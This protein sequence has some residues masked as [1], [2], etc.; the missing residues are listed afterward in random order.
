MKPTSQ[1]LL[2]TVL[3]LA[4]VLSGL[5]LASAAENQ[6]IGSPE[7]SLTVP[8]NRVVPGETKRLNVSIVNDGVIRRGGPERFTAR[9]TTARAVTLDIA[10]VAG[11]DIETDDVAV[12]SVPEGVVGPVPI[13]ITVP[14]G[15]PPGRYQLPIEV[16]YTFTS[17]VTYDEEAPDDNPAF[18]DRTVTRRLSIPV[19]VEDRAR[20]RV[21]DVS[22]DVQVGDSGTMVASVR[23]VGTEPAREASV[24]LAS[25]NAD[26]TFGGSQSA[27]GFVGDW[28][29]GEVKQVTFPVAVADGAELRDYT[30]TGQVTYTDTDGLV[31]GSNELRASV[32]PLAE[33]AFSLS[34]VES[35]LRVNWEGTV[36]G[37]V[38]NEGPAP[39]TDAVVVFQPTN[40]NF[41]ASETEYAI[42]DLAPGESAEFAFDVEVSSAADPGSRQLR[43]AVDYENE[44]GDARTSDPLTSRVSVEGEREP[45]T[46]EASASTIAA[47]ESG[48]LTLTVT[49]AEDET[50]SD[51]SA[52]LF[53]DDPISSSDDEAFVGELEPGESA[54]ITFAVS[55]GGSTFAKDYP[56]S[57]DFEY[58]RADGTTQVSDTFRLPVT[59]EE[60]GGGGLPI[61]LI[62]GIGAV[63]LVGAAFV[64]VRRR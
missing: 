36:T 58:D 57:V 63:V 48:R 9:V 31:Q 14:E 44:D 2:V 25:S 5:P 62:V 8:D 56:V 28:R 30:V 27:E 39:I 24:G 26:L 7:L 42:P 6:V 18:T 1:Q 12:G 64:V 10:D 49:N 41:D 54:E 20:F 21:V 3:A 38:T 47:G 29:P 40:P 11:L 23:N 59:V 51:I 46:V 61:G 52:K 55:T 53:V 15:V 4:V 17:I 22:T 16:S 13:E 19:V 35:S 45:F 43:F 60:S 32:R 33:Q 34:G 37:T 50:L